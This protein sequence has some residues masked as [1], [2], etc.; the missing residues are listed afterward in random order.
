[1]LQNMLIHVRDAV[2]SLPLLCSVVGIAGTVT[3]MLGFV[4]FRQFFQSWKLIFKVRDGGSAGAISPI[5][6][7]LKSLS[8]SLGNG[9]LA[10][11]ATALH[12]GGPG[13]AFWIFFIGLFGMALRFAEVYL[14]NAFSGISKAG[15]ALGGPFLYLQ[16]VPG[17]KVLPYVYAALC[18]GYGL[19]S[20]T[21]MQCNSISMSITQ[22]VSSI[23]VWSI[24]L[25]LT[26]FILYTL[27]GG[28]QRIVKVN[29]VIVPL[30]VILFFTVCTGVLLYHWTAIPA[31]ISLI[32]K[33]AF[34]PQAFTGGALGVTVIHV[35]RLSMARTI[36]ASEIGLGTAGVIYGATGSKDPLD[37]GLSAMLGTFISVNLVCSMV[38]LSIVA[39]GALDSGTTGAALTSI[40]FQSAFG[41]FGGWSVTLLSIL[42]GMGVF[43]AYGFIGR[44][45]WL[46]LTGHRFE[47]VFTVLFCAVSFWGAV[48]DVSVVWASVDIINAGCLVINLFAVVWLLPFMR[49]K[50]LPALA[51]RD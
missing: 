35:F 24:G 47:H 45:C 36:N 30:K 15:K 22:M 6:A 5:Q 29:S 18:L 49:S 17:G 7:F 8:T 20:G 46:F 33:A 1:M 40:A 27:L 21:A 37:N 32:V 4:Q 31:A 11:I 41:A 12:A 9:A 34:N 16:K 25:V 44:E 14:S 2:W 26:V 48:S 13:A 51:K 42:F 19:F 3:V 28:A 23:S 50:V 10:G 43:V 38:A 39:S